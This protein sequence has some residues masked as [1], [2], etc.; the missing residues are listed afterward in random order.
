MFI[1][2]SEVKVKIKVCFEELFKIY[3]DLMCEKKKLKKK[4]VKFGENILF[5]II[6]SN[7]YYIKEIISDDFDIVRSNFFYIKEIISDDVS[8]ININ[9]LKKIMRVVKNKLRNIQLVIENFNDDVSVE[10]DK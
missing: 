5:D 3:S 10:E 8:V 7:F 1:V 2:E 9:N 4:F 6:R